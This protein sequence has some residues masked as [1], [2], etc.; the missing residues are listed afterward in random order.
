MKSE[1]PDLPDAGFLGAVSRSS[2]FHILV[3]GFVS[4][5]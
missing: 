4:V 3:K 5:R 1:Y 2:L